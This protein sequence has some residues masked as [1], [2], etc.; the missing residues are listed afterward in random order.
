MKTKFSFVMLVLA[1]LLGQAAQAASTIDRSFPANNS[2][3]ISSEQR[4]QWARAADDIEDLQSTTLKAANNLSDV[5]NAATARTNLGIAAL[6]VKSVADLTTDVTGILPKANGGNGTATPALTP[7]S[8]I[9]ITGTWPNYTIS[10]TGGGGGSTSP[11]GADG[12]IQY[13]NGGAFGGLALLPVDKGG[14]GTATPGLMPGTNVSIT[15]SWPNQTINAVGGGTPGGLN[16]TV[17]INSSGSFAGVPYWQFAANMVSQP[18]LPKWE[19]KKQAF[20]GLNNGRVRMLVMGDSTAVSGVNP[21]IGW[22]YQLANAFQNTGIK[23]THGATFGG[24]FD[25]DTQRVTIGSSWARDTTISTV[26]GDTYKA[27]TNTNALSFLSSWPISV[28]R[29]WY[30][31]QPTGGSFTVDVGGVTPATVSTTGTLAL[32]SYDWTSGGTTF[33]KSACNVK[34]ASG[35]QVNISGFET[36]DGGGVTIINTAL[37][38]SAIAGWS[39][40]TTAIS[41]LNGVLAIN[42]DIVIMGPGVN[43]MPGTSLSAYQTQIETVV[44]ALKAAN[45]EVIMLSPFPQNP[46]DGTHN[47][48]I[49]TQDGYVNVNRTVASTLNLPYIGFYEYFGSYA[50]SAGADYDRYMT[51]PGENWVHPNYKG[52]AAATDLIFSYLMGFRPGNVSDQSVYYHTINALNGYSIRGGI[53][54]SRGG[55]NSVI[56]GVTG[57]TTNMTGIQNTVVG[58]GAL[59][60]VG[61]GFGHVAIGYQALLALPNAGTQYNVAVGHQAGANLTSSFN[62]FVGKDAGKKFSSGANNIALGKGA[63]SVTCQTGSNNILIG[64]GVDCPAAGTANYLNVGATLTGS[65]L[66]TDPY[67]LAP[68]IAGQCGVLRGANFNVTTD[69]AITINLPNAASKWVIERIFVTNP[70]ISLTTA[71]GGVYSAVSKGG[72]ALVAS[73][74]TYTDAVASDDVQVA[75]LTAAGQKKSFSSGTVYLSLTTAQGAAAT[76]DVY[77][78]CRPF[79]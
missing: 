6:G 70:S 42:P 74:Q 63:A 27:T 25:V 16:N 73:S 26:G 3:L 41:W 76:A 64:V 8:N 66:T 57:A 15:G 32:M 67:V 38:G 30:I 69:Q 55:V 56:V 60:I 18:K 29:I 2:A 49:A 21:D 48:S 39:S 65:T 12:Y 13:N 14:T 7:G 61:A 19:A 59:P 50:F 9:I 43:S 45:I 24:L 68:G 46:A 58:D 11:G 17:Q 35:G 40:Q 52:T 79:K 10:A 31:Q 1:L 72:V 77:V 71:A 47:V 22:P 62:T 78:I 75:T 4:A 54:L 28:C 5:A 33:N 36:W 44:N 51:S 20:G 53:N 34:W 23:A 37:G